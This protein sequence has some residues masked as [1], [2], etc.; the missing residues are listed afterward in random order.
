[1]LLI[2]PTKHTACEKNHHQHHQHAHAQPHS[3]QLRCPPQTGGGEGRKQLDHLFIVEPD[4]V[5][6]EEELQRGGQ[7]QQVWAACHGGSRHIPQHPLAVAS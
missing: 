1:M 5:K 7:E 2:K 4:F 6:N 3:P